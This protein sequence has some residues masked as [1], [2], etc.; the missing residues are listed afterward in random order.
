[1]T[2][3]S[4]NESDSPLGS[5]GTSLDAAR[6]WELIQAG[7]GL[8]AELDLERVIGELLDVAR[9]VTGARYAALGVLDERRVELERFIT[10]GIEPDRH[11]AIGDLPRG[12]GILGL[13]IDDPQ[14]LRLS[15]IGDHPK[16]YGFPP[17]HPQMHSFHGV[18]ILFRNEAFG[19]LYL[20]DKAG[21]DFDESDEQAVVILA[22]WA[23][24]AMQNARLY[25]ADAARRDALERANRGLEAT[26][27][28][29]RAVGAETD[30]EILLDLIVKRARAL[31]DART[32]VVWLQR[33]DELAV[34]ASAG[35][36]PRHVDE[37]RIPLIG[38]VS[39]DVVRSG[40]GERIGD[41]GAALHLSL[42]RLGLEASAALLV[43][44]SYRGRVSGLMAAYDHLGPESRFSPEDEDLLQ[45]FA[46]SAATAVANAQDVA[47]QR[48][49]QSL[50]A[51]EQ[52]RARWAR[53][54]HDETLQGLASL[55]IGLRTARRSGDQAIE[56]DAIDAA[57]DQIQL[58][59]GNL[60][61]LITQLRPAALDELGVEAAIDGL[62][63]RVPSD[64]PTVAVKIDLDYEHG[65]HPTRP[66]PEL[67]ATIYRLV[68]EALNN[69]VVHAHAGT[70]RIEVVEFEGAVTIVVADDGGGF[71]PAGRSEGF[72]LVGMRERVEL[73][74]GTLR[75]TSRPGG[76]TTVL[77]TLPVRHRPRA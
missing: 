1:M 17:G 6:L 33:G 30:L 62:V 47:D 36:T 70:V 31:V 50:H 53:E 2:Q 46:A 77:A 55:V 28:I 51:A 54:L 75:I 27:T 69:A 56:E 42:D 58:E 21:G 18:P 12:R 48:L 34:A 72:G 23:A 7:R 32:L 44:L 59:I 57:L 73:A 37:A 43:P 3:L 19:N 41:A 22:A 71:D 5:S 8:V 25:G 64:G 66:E 14:P 67:E 20:T 24:V 45:S 35:E 65:R 4:G 13:L 10:R 52:E 9:R 26:T 16:A 29:A 49:R 68:Q 40:V 39:G 74:G 11:R 38:S 15:E 61:A 60:R 76:G 63:D